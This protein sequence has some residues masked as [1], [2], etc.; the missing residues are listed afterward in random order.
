MAPGRS[1]GGVRGG[2]GVEPGGLV[3]QA[4]GVVTGGFVLGRIRE[5]LELFNA[6]NQQFA[7]RPGAGALRKDDAIGQVHSG[8]G[9][10]ME[11]GVRGLGIA[12]GFEGGADLAQHGQVV[13]FDDGRGLTKGQVLGKCVRC[14]RIAAFCF[15]RFSGLRQGFPP[16]RME[17]RALRRARPRGIGSSEPALAD[18]GGP[19]PSGT[20]TLLLA[21]GRFFAL[22][23]RRRFSLTP[24]MQDFRCINI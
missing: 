3:G 16:I 22:S 11:R 6:T 23:R 14:S 4:A 13:G 8:D 2:V 19:T 12:D 24:Y 10:I 17:A 15:V 9:E 20:C 5:H 21:T 18:Q 7:S 1:F